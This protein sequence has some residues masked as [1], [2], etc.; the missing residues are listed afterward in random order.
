[1]YYTQFDEKSKVLYKTEILEPEVA[2]DKDITVVHAEKKRY[3]QKRFA[4]IYLDSAKYL[5]GVITKSNFGLFLHLL[6][7]MGN[8]DNIIN[9]T[10]EE[11][12]KACKISLSTIQRSMDAFEECGFICKDRRGKWIVN[13][14][15]AAKVDEDKKNAI[16]VNYM[17]TKH[18]DK[19]QTALSNE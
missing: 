13:P 10:Y 15:M 6:Q 9:E 12:A 2:G 4:K 17:D 3:A 1:M 5:V 7:K 8:G 11:M 14:Y 16:I 19:D 18:R